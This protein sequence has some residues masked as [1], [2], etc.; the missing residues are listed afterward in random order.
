[1]SVTADPPANPRR[2]GR[3]IQDW[4]PDDPGFWA[5]TGKKIAN[6]NLIFSVIT[7]HIGFSIWSLWSVMVLFMGTKYGL[8]VGDKF[9]LTSLPTLVGS[10]LRIPYNLAVAAFG[11]RN[12]T[13]I[14][15]LLLLIPAALCAVVMHPGTSLGTFLWVSAVAGVGGGNFASSMTNINTFYPENRKGWALGLN[16]GG[17]NL[18]VAVVQ[19]VA[20]LVL[21]T[22]GAMQPRVVLWIYLPII[23]IGAVLAVLFMDNLATAKNDTKAMREVIKD[24]HA[25]IISLLYVGTFGSFIGYSFAFGQVLQ[26]QFHRTPLQAAYLTFLG[27]LLGSLSRPIGGWLSD[28]IGGAWVTFINFVLMAGSTG[29]VIAASNAKS[30]SLFAVGFMLLFVLSGVGNGSVYKMIPSIF[31]NKALS[32]IDGGAPAEPALLRARRLSG[33]LIGIAGALGAL[34]GVLI[35]LAFRESFLSVKTGVPAFIGF[36]VFYAICFVVTWLVYLRSAAA[37]SATATESK[38][39]LRV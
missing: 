8:S 7:E 14:S 15:A 9:L 29:V 30:L 39:E 2:G 24:G 23:V 20:L 33:A 13:I 32:A 10:V 3:W 4:R 17:G 25:W 34:G 11:G 6:R 27:P 1:M 28:R 37:K 22:A 16:A 38:S 5:S 35:N 18:G 36:L 19:L 12:W 26:N 31:K 21:A